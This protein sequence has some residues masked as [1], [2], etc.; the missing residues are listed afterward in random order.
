MEEE[1]FSRCRALIDSH[2]STR[3]KK[4]NA[5]FFFMLPTPLHTNLFEQAKDS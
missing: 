5:L 4:K 2:N 3:A 1:S